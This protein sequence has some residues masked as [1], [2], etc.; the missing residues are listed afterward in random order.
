MAK[1]LVVALRYVSDFGTPKQTHLVFHDRV[2]RAV[3]AFTNTKEMHIFVTK[4]LNQRDE[5]GT[6][7]FDRLPEVHPAHQSIP[8]FDT[9]QQALDYFRA[10]RERLAARLKK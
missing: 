7:W 5:T 8:T 2:N 9:A 1:T 10:E 3:C 4:A 6:E